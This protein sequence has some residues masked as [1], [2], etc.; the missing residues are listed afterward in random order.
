MGTLIG[1]LRVSLKGTLK[2][3]L[4]PYSNYQGPKIIVPLKTPY[5]IP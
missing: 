2:G 4:K 1:A 5:S 3:T